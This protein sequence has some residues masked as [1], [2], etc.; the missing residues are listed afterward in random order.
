MTTETQEQ[1]QDLSIE[2][3]LAS[4]R[5]IISDDDDPAKAASAAPTSATMPAQAAPDVDLEEEDDEILNL[6]EEMIEQA[7][8]IAPAAE[9]M[10]QPDDIIEFTEPEPTK[11]EI[12][13]PDPDQF[14]ELP[15]VS[16]QEAQGVDG[17]DGI[18]S[19]SAA[20][21]TMG[22]FAKLAENVLIEKP[23]GVRAAS[24]P[25]LEEIVR[26]IL[27]PMLR[28][29]IDKNVPRIVERAVQEELEKLA[30]RARDD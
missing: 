5:Q 11:P 3:I 29:W 7:P 16:V 19:D 23:S 12:V 2:E 21:A 25:S 4:I 26:D 28:D 13:K 30:R 6:T 1:P 20:A 24:G 14:I 10:S 9:P 22:A 17:E 27:K 18:F 8:Q 15:S